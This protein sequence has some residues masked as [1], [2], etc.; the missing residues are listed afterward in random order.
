[1][2]APA[3]QIKERDTLCRHLFECFV[4]SLSCC[5]VVGEAALVSHA[6]MVQTAVCLY[7][8]LRHLCKS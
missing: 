1:M 7:V 4:L 8:S 5:G 2:H 3:L 6:V